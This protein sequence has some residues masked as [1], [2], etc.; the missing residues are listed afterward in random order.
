MLQ[1]FRNVVSVTT[2]GNYLEGR[3]FTIK[4]THYEPAAMN[5]EENKRKRSEYVQVLNH[6]IEQGKQIVWIDETNFSLFC[7]R[8]R[9]R[10]RVGS[11]AIQQLPS[12]RGSN[13][14][15]IGAISTAGVVTME[16]RRGP[17]T[18][19]LANEW[20]TSLL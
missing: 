4:Q 5:I 3:V 1:I 2:V 14:H 11:R 18:T 13:V 19:N 17:F 12:A 16:R 9:G 10:A 15:L 7:R 20:A 8:T 6:Y